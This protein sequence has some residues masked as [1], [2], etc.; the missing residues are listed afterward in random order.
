MMD[1]FS[2]TCVQNVAVTQRSKVFQTADSTA[3][4]ETC[5]VQRDDLVVT[6]NRKR[7]IRVG[8]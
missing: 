7:E 8:S 1:S 3:T 2:L 6:F 4:T 5:H